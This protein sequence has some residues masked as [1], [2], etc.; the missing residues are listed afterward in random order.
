MLLAS[1]IF[2]QF[3]TG[4]AGQHNSGYKKRQDR[5]RDKTIWRAEKN[6]ELKITSKQKEIRIFSKQDKWLGHEFDETG[7]TPNTEKVKPILELKHP[8]KQKQLKSVLGAKQ[9]L[10]KLYREY[11]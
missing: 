7:N 4:L 9:Y 2:R 1:I 6:T 10:T 8:E 5:P 11:R 3:H